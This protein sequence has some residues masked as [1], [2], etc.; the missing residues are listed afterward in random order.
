MEFVFQILADL[1]A[2]VDEKQVKAE[3]EKKALES[4]EE[5]AKEQV[6]ETKPEEPNI[7]GV[8]DFH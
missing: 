7:F 2:P 4:K 8:M 6:V 1:L 3:A 5:L